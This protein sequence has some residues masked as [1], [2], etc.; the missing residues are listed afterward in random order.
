ML[1]LYFQPIRFVK[2]DSESVNRGLPGLEA[3]RG[4]DPWRSP[5]GS[6]ALIWGRECVV[7]SGDLKD[8]WYLYVLV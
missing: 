6:Q 5:N 8:F 4:L 1:V 2:F 7:A 3:A